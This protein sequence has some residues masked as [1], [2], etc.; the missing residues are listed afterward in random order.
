[1]IK[2]VFENGN[3]ADLRHVAVDALV[4]NKQGDKL[5]LEKRAKHLL[6]HSGKWCLPGGFLNRNETLAEGIR[7]EIREETGYEVSSLELF[8]INDKPN[9]LGE[10]RQ[11]ATFVFLARASKKTRA[12]DD[13]VQE[14]KWFKLDEM[15]SKDDFAFDHHE[16]IEFF[17]KH[18]KHPFGLPL[19]PKI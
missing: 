15:P 5:L 8:R 10:D 6:L 17:I 13:E 12:G 2:C 16:N 19:M 9:R 11:N 7:R 3:K 1:M 18:Q 14:A 4:I